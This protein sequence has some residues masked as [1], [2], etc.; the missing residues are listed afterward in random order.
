MLKQEAKRIYFDSVKVERFRESFLKH[1]EVLPVIDKRDE[2]YYCGDCKS[3]SSKQQLAFSKEST[4]FIYDR[5]GSLGKPTELWIVKPHYDG[6][7]G[8]N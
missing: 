8:W 1:L 4:I 3:F 7:R 2:G 6:C 5:P